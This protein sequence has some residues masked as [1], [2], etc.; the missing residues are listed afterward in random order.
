MTYG[1]IRREGVEER[2][3]KVRA[4]AST[5]FAPQN[6]ASEFKGNSLQDHAEAYLSEGKGWYR[7]V[8]AANA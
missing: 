1:E 2:G 4:A 8:E 7:N 6:H 3:V 5:T